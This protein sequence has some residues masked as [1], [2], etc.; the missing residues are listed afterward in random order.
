[1][2]GF[3]TPHFWTCNDLWMHSWRLIVL[4]VYIDADTSGQHSG[5]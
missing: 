5:R 1:M 2:T 3:H 4:A